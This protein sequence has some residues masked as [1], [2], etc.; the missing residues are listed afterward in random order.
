MISSHCIVVAAHIFRCSPFSR[1]F[2][3]NACTWEAVL[4]GSERLQGL[5]WSFGRRRVRICGS[6][7]AFPPVVPARVV[8]AADEPKQVWARAKSRVIE[9]RVLSAAGPWRTSGD[10]WTTTPWAREDWDL[11]LSNGALYRLY[12]EYFTG[13][14]FLDGEYD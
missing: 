6:T 14:W 9:G 4:S 11:S 7:L 12:R 8:S 10:W 5:L 1:E 13:A 3:D 2:L